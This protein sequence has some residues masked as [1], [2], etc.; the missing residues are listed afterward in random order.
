VERTPRIHLDVNGGI[1]ADVGFRQNY[2]A[3]AGKFL[4]G[5]GNWIELENVK[6]EDLPEIK[7]LEVPN[8]RMGSTTLVGGTKTIANTSITANTRIFI[9]I[10]QL[11]TVL[12]P[13]AIA[14]TAKVPGASFTIESE[15][16]TDTSQL[17]YILVE[18]L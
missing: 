3:T 11:G 5:N 8:G 18:P 4:R 9:S 7:I 14:I 6:S 12:T 1:N 15:D 2:A 16:P 13:K 17:A 10:Q